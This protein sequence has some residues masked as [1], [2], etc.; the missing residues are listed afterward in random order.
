MRFSYSV[1]IAAYLEHFSK[2]SQELTLRK[3]NRIYQ[4]C[5]SIFWITRRVNPVTCLQ[6]TDQSLRSLGPA[7]GERMIF[8]KRKPAYPGSRFHQE[9]ITSLAILCRGVPG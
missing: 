4:H 5:S 9:K 7:I 8:T 3:I 1:V 2:L 6:W